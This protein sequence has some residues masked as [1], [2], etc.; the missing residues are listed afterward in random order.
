M[1]IDLADM[2]D[3]KNSNNKGYRYI[4]ITFDNFSKISCAIPLK[5]KYGQVITNKFPNI[6]TTSK[7][8]PLKL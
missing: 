7:R 1:V 6:L 5:K 2:I 4:F 3:Y 8:R